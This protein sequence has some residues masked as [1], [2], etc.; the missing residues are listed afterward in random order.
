MIDEAD[1]FVKAGNGGDGR[2]SFH[3]SK[4]KP[5]GGPDGGDGGDGGSVYLLTDPNPNTL[6]FFSG[7]DRFEAENGEMGKKDKKHGRDGEDITIKIPAGTV[8]Y[9]I[10][11]NSW[12]LLFDLDKPG[13]KVLLAEG[14]RG[15]RGNWQFR[16]STNQ[17]PRQAEPGQSGQKKQI[18]LELRFLAQVGLVG[19][20]NAGKSTLLSVLTRAKP[21]IANYPFTTL[22]PN[23]GVIEFQDGASLVMAD[24]P[25]LIEGAS[26]GKGLGFR[27][28]KH[29]QR[30]QLLI[31][32]LFPDQG[33]LGSAKIGQ[34]LFDQ[35]AQVQKEIKAFKEKLIGL[36]SL[37][38]INKKD[39][40]T[41]E[42]TRGI[43]KF[44][45]KKGQNIL[46]VSAATKENLDL[47]KKSLRRPIK[48]I[49]PYYAIKP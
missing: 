21:E 44:F 13:V 20:P 40:L 24:I 36:P 14:G 37:I 43:A 3:H 11:K 9:Q 23:L 47:L 10:K 7:K 32:V 6:R 33:M 45:K 19:L 17:T 12:K 49:Q 31:Y 39:L 48:T 34:M 28:L 15:G 18:H 22:S 35:L 4:H 1:F 25:G 2:V 29:I 42:Q 16:S 8:V 26:M 38:I 27:F 46:L 41:A 5:R 30:C